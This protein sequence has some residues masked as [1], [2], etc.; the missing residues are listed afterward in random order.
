MN[1][2]TKTSFMH[3]LQ[4]EVKQCYTYSKVDLL[5][6]DAGWGVAQLLVGAGDFLL[7]CI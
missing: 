7:L 1:A 5:R 2:H 4:A 3:T 6:E